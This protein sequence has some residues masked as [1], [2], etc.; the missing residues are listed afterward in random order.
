MQIK[1]I[2]ALLLVLIVA[3]SHKIEEENHELLPFAMGYGWGR[4]RGFRGRYGFGGFG[5]RGFGFGRGFGGYGYKHNQDDN[6]D[7]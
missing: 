7:Q 1:I 3:Q 6:N 5:R 4:S 2:L